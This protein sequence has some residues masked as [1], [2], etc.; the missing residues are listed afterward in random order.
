M[1]LMEKSGRKPVSIPKSLVSQFKA[2]GWQEKI[3]DSAV[4]SDVTPELTP[5]TTSE[6][7]VELDKIITIAQ[8]NKMNQEGL[9]EVAAEYS[10]DITDCAS[11]KEAVKLI[12][13]IL[14][15]Q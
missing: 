14:D 15:L 13:D 2:A 6:E 12:A 8:L 10:I 7:F 4:A 11:K 5:D 9:K 3:S 1:V